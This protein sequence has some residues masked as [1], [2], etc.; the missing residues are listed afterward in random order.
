MSIMCQYQACACRWYNNQPVASLNTG[1]WQ[2]DRPNN[3]H[4]SSSLIINDHPLGG[5]RWGSPPLGVLK[6]QWFEVF[7]MVPFVAIHPALSGGL[8]ALTHN[9]ATLF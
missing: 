7:Q 2:C 5:P 1:M 6:L 3:L 4:Q 9:G 8:V